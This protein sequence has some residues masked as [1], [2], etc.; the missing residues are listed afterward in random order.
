MGTTVRETV[1][2]IYEICDYIESEGQLKQAPPYPLRK[3]QEQAFLNFLVYLSYAD[4]RYS[5][6][7]QSFLKEALDQDVTEKEARE[8]RSSRGLTEGKFGRN[9]PTSVKYFFVSCTP[10]PW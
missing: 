3:I 5:P 9:V 1:E 8:L 10:Q 4:G 2:E 7:E 6:D